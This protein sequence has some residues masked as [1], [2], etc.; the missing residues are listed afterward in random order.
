MKN[1]HSIG[2]WITTDNYESTE[3]ILQYNFDWIC[4]DLE[5]ST[6]SLESLKKIISLCE[7]YNKKSYVRIAEINKA[8]INKILD[9]GACGLIVANIKN[10]EDVQKCFDYAFYSPKGNR[11][12]GLSRSQGYGNKFDEY[13]T[14][15]SKNIEIIPII[16]SKEAIKNLKD[17]LSY[18]DIKKSMI[19][20]YDLSSSINKPGNFDSKEFKSLIESYNV[21]SKSLKKEKGIHIVEPI[22]GEVDKRINENYQFIAFSTDAI[23][24][25]RTL[26]KLTK[27]F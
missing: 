2:T 1:E 23:I 9:A 27:G 5:H 8:L 11:G 25:D 3:I 7:K 6:I 14:K 17:I 24:L 16:E 20:P 26:S 4:V 13:I 22:P 15:D 18:K 21:I 10:V 12:M 19:G